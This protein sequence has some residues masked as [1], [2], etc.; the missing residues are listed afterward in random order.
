[1]TPREARLGSMSGAAATV[2][3]MSP[4]ITSPLV[5]SQW[6]AD[7]LGADDMV[8]VDV[9]VLPVRGRDGATTGRFTTGRGDYLEH[10]HV[11]GAVFGDLIH[12]LSDDRAALP[13]T[14]PD[15]DRFAEA[16]GALGITSDTTVIAYDSA[17]GPWAARLWWLLR[18]AGHDDAAV[19]DGGFTAWAAEGRPVDVGHVDPE[20]SVFVAH[21]RPELWV[22]KP[23]VEAVVRGDERASLVCGSP[24]DE[25][26]GTAGAR[27]RRGHI[28]GSV[29]VPATEL[30][31][32][33]LRFE[34]PDRLEAVFAPVLD[35]EKVVVYCGQGIA[36]SADAL[37]LVLVGH[38]DVVL[39][40][41]SLDEWAG[42]DDAPLEVLAA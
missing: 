10:G 28:P 18:A 27:P 16:A 9:S 15:V 30:V 2:A 11:P 6:V 23:F 4:V 5:S 39:Y 13:F 42:D 37:A 21:E 25:F 3:R 32:D 24:R 40:D 35:A 17:G 8:V 26:V 12:D 38:D 34:Q 22:D 20:P 7:H 14:R 36:A 31:D 1:V 19:L 33:E 29:N 41:G